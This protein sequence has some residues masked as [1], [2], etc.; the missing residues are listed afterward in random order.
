MFNALADG[1]PS[2]GACLRDSVALVTGAG[3]GIGRTVSAALAGAGAAVALVARSGDALAH[4]V[5]LVEAAA[6]P[7]RPPSPTSPTPRR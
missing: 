1:A 4:T 7:Q 2:S 3:R 6:A 5:D